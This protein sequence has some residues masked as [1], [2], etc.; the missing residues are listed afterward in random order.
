MYQEV[1]LFITGKLRAMYPTV[2]LYTEQA[3]TH[4]HPTGFSTNTIY[5]WVAN[6]E[7]V[8]RLVEQ[9]V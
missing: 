9:R 4:T 3:D 8:Y 2:E 1:L 7:I 5:N 6:G